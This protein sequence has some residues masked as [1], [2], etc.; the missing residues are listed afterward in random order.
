MDIK[1]YA[2]ALESLHDPFVLADRQHI[3]RFINEAGARNYAKWGGRELLGKSL[4][5]CHNEE[6]RAMIE[7][8][9]VA[10]V[11]GEEERMISDNGQRRIY[12]RAVRAEDG[13]LLG[14][15]E[16]YEFASFQTNP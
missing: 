12:M 1:L 4:M 6:S 15:Y 3:V 2:A 8:I 9:I 14:Y 7:E 11:A 13:A 5:E 16:R 10:M